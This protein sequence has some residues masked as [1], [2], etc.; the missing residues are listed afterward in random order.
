MSYTTPKPT[1]KKTKAKGKAVRV[2]AVVEITKPDKP[3][4]L[5]KLDPIS[6]AYLEEGAK[7]SAR[8][9][10]EAGSE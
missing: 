4:D 5:A 3:L 6:K 7:A 2:E 8:E 9:E 10:A 1:T